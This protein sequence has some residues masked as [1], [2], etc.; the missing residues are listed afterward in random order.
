MSELLDLIADEKDVEGRILFTG[1]TVH[2][3]GFGHVA[4]LPVLTGREMMA[5]DYY[6]FSTKLVEYN[7]PPV[8]W[9]KREGGMEEFLPLYNVSHV[10]V[11][12][13]NWHRWAGEHPELLTR[14]GGVAPERPIEL[15]RVNQRST[16]FLQ[17]RGTVHADARE[18][19]VELEDPDAE[20]VIKYNFDERLKVSSPAELF[21]FDS[22]KHTRFIGIRPNGASS[23][24]IRLK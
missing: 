16:W 13:R 3:Y 21:A 19:R 23:V 14:I 9:R 12:K 20:A 1:S 10:L 15:Y 6:H 4:Y 18:I 2:R 17:G 24:T 7:Y 5:C 22:S 11:H 8:Y